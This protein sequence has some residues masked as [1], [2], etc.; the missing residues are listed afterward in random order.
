MNV[1]PTAPSGRPRSSGGSISSATVVQPLS[2]PTSTKSKV[3]TPKRGYD[4]ADLE[5]SG[6]SADEGAQGKGDKRRQPGVKRACNECRQQK[7]SY[8]CLQCAVQP[9]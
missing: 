7:A 9:G 4:T 8:A 6:E 5:S 1:P 2:S 3:R